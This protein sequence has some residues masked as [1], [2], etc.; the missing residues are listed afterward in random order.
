MQ[1]KSNEVKLIR[2]QV[3]NIF[4][5]KAAEID[6]N[7]NSIVLTGPNR[8]GKSS[9]LDALALTIGQ[10]KNGNPVK[11]GENKGQVIAEFDH[12]VV[13]RKWKNGKSQS[14]KIESK[15]GDKFGT[16]SELFKEFIDAITFK[17]AEFINLS[18]KDRIRQLYKVAGIDYEAYL[19]KRKV[20][21]DQRTDVGRE[22]KKIEG[23][24]KTL[25][26]PQSNI[27]DN[28][29]SVSE[30][31]D[32][33]SSLREKENSKRELELDMRRLSDNLEYKKEQLSEAELKIKGID[34]EITEY[35]NQIK[36]QTE[37]LV[38]ADSIDNQ[39]KNI[40]NEIE[41]LELK[42]EALKAKKEEL[43]EQKSDQEHR[44][45][46]IDGLNNEI[47]SLNQLKISH[48]QQA[49]SIQN[50]VESLEKNLN[51]SKAKLEQ[52][53]NYSNEIEAHINQLQNA[54]K[55]NQAVR[56]K[57]H[58]EETH[59]K[60]EHLVNQYD[61]LSDELTMLDDTLKAQLNSVELPDG[62]NIDDNEIY[63]D[64]IP[65]DRLST[66]QK[67]D[68]AMKIG[69]QIRPQNGNISFKALTMDISQF[70]EDQ[71]SEAIELANRNGYQAIV[72]V[73]SV[74]KGDYGD[75]NVFYIE[76]GSVKEAQNVG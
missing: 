6:A 20:K 60:V 26:L 39:L 13:T 58:F 67:L 29:I 36:N 34:D 49:K 57:K 50:V 62:L 51:S 18:A 27:P 41:D 74:N 38:D 43:L 42:L 70:D 52:M 28:E 33:I 53:P 4:G 21:Y 7:G 73:A 14:W 12:F 1:N 45:D 32:I 65:F 72:E 44:K 59:L 35:E 40:N 11:L 9:I 75:A 54:E 3:E 22:K 10:Q 46:R 5:V 17:P 24:F 69:M 76:N 37:K 15:N 71:R 31:N 55:I 61:N 47:D 8:A 68:L 2:L 25:K 23:Y 48:T 63:I 19:A 16:P 30:V 66:M 56:A 64:N